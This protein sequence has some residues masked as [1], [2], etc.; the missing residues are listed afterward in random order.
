MAQSINKRAHRQTTKA[1]VFFITDKEL[2][3][4]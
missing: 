4:T 3:F 2:I 1:C